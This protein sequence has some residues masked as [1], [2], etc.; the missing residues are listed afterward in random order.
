MAPHVILDIY[1]SNLT[2]ITV[3]LV[4]CLL[5]LQNIGVFSWSFSRWAWHRLDT[6]FRSVENNCGLMRRLTSLNLVTWLEV[7]MLDIFTTE[8]TSRLSCEARSIFWNPRVI[9]ARWLWKLVSKECQLFLVWTLRFIHRLGII[10]IA[11][12]L[13]KCH[14]VRLSRLTMKFFYLKVHMTALWETSG[15]NWSRLPWVNEWLIL[16]WLELR[17]VGYLAC[18]FFGRDFFHLLHRW[19][20]LGF[21]FHWFLRL[22]FFWWLRLE[23]ATEP[24]EV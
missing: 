21:A 16:S 7:T 18:I 15:P 13:V 12:W 2:E 20:L 8:Q 14:L 19:R 17:P 6:F 1:W 22:K 10:H 5:L 24:I 4:C 9:R 23:E 3:F 11:V